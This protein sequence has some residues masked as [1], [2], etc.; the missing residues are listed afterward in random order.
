MASV[1]LIRILMLAIIA[2]GV[3]FIFVNLYWKLI[4]KYH[5][6]KQIRTDAPS[7]YE[8]HQ[9]KEGTPTMAGVVIWLTVLVL[10]LTF[11]LLAKWFNGFWSGF[12]FLSRSQTYL[13]LGTMVGAALVGLID[14]LLGVFKKG[15]GGGGLSLR[16]KL[17]IY[18]LISSLGA[19]WFWLKLGWDVLYVPFIGPVFLGYWFIPFFI[20]ILVASTLSAN[21]T[22]GLDG[23]LGGVA[24]IALVALMAVCFFEG[25]YD[26]AAFL[27][28]TIG[29]L[30]TFLWFNIYPAKFFMGDTGAVALGMIIGVVS[31]LTQTA[32]L[33]PFFAFI[34]VLESLSVIIQL[35]SRKLFH[36]KLFL[37]T[38]LHHH[39]EAKGWPESQITMRFWMISGLMAALGII[40]FF[41]DKLRF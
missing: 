7:F 36:K 4:K 39:F 5:L 14:D 37:L 8:L 40:L 21:E 24:T 26:L 29:S 13:P 16:H 12:N 11:F 15:P 38:P 41:L 28:V 25:K 31:I 22:D 30:I 33:L 1:Q 6:G 27:A 32:L 19:L 23:L 35:L 9:K 10:S 3:S 17:I 18:I 2:F 20:F 34:L